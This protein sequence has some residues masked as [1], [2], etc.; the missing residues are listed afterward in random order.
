MQ[1]TQENNGLVFIVWTLSMQ[2]PTQSEYQGDFWHGYPKCFARE[3]KNPVTGNTMGELYE[4]TLQR[5]DYLTSQGF[6]VVEKWECEL[7]KELSE[8]EETSEYFGN[9]TIAEPLEPRHAL[10]GGR[11]N[12]V[13]LHH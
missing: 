1:E 8:S 3:T 12:A 10:F 4:K 5:R 2:K 11:T 6:R 9:C 13:K 7:K